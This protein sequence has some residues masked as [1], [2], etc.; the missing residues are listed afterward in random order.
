MYIVYGINSPCFEVL[1]K[2]GVLNFI[3]ENKFLKYNRILLYLH[4]DQ[5]HL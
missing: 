4:V 5:N 3:K 1:F 2:M